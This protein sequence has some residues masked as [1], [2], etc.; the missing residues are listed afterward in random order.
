MH[1][2]DPISNVPAHSIVKQAD[3]EYLYP[4]QVT[5]PAGKAS[6]LALHFRVK[7]GLHINSHTPRENFLIPTTFSIPD[8]SGVRLESVDFPPGADFALPFDPN[9]K[10]SVYT[11]EFAI[12]ARIVPAAGDHLVRAKL[13]YQACTNNT[14]FPPKTVTVPIDVVG[15]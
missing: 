10:L 13:H 3:V 14:C 1:G 12:D 6:K 5:L 9:E 4:E 15:K 11:G 7:Q 8:D 2:Q